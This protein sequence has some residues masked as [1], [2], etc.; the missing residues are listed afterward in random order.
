MCVTPA[1]RTLQL[2]ASTARVAMLHEKETRALDIK[3]RR[4][5]IYA[6]AHRLGLPPDA[7]RRSPPTL[8]AVSTVLLPASMLASRM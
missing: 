4:R 3:A 1:T 5:R 7:V 6:Q 8:V 2:L